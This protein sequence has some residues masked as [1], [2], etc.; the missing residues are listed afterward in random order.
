MQIKLL[1]ESINL[2]EPPIKDAEQL[3]IPRRT[4][5]LTPSRMVPPD[6]LALKGL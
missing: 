3:L 1:P 2:V 6:L 5:L 4:V